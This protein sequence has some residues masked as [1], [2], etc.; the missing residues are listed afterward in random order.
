[1]NLDTDRLPDFDHTVFPILNNSQLM[2]VFASSLIKDQRKF[3]S[4][5]MNVTAT[6]V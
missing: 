4:T 3:Y 1:M 6:V 5:L 2:V